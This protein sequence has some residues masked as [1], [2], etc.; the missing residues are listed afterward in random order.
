MIWMAL[1][2][3]SLISQTHI[4]AGFFGLLGFPIMAVVYA[5]IRKSNDTS[6]EEADP[7]S[8]TAPAGMAEF[9]DTH[10]EFR[11]AVPRLRVAAFHKWLNNESLRDLQ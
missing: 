10:P 9:L 8:S 6:K 1:L 2:A 4:D 11:N 7:D 5:F 3:C